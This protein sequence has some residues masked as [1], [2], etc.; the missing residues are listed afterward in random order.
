MLAVVADDPADALARCEALSAFRASSDDMEDLSV[1]YTRAKN[2]AKPEL[3]VESDRAIMGPQEIALADALEQAEAVGRELMQ[4]RAYSMTLEALAALR[5][6][7][8]D[9]LRGR[10]G[11]G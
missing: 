1:A 4:Q 2:L 10:S 5:A 11:H 9:V 8:D 6:P 7:I 3:G